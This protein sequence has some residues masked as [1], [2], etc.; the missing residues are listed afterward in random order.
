MAWIGVYKIMK[1][2]V[3]MLL[4]DSQKKFI[5]MFENYDFAFDFVDYENTISD[6][7]F[8]I[9]SCRRKNSGCC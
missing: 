2:Y 6:L 1:Y 3:Y 8:I 4:D 9:I 5:A 7:D